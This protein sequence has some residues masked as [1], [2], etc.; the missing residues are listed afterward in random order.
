MIR[1]LPAILA[2][3]LAACSSD[4]AVVHADAEADTAPDVAAEVDTAPDVAPDV[5]PD[6]PP[7]V[8][9][10]ADPGPIGCLHDPACEKVFLSAHRAKCGGEPENTLAGIE[11]CLD[12]GIPML[13][14]DT[15]ATADGHIVLMHDGDTERTTDGEERHPD[16]YAVGDLTLAEFEA[17]VVDDERCADDPEAT[18][19]RCHPPS[20]ADALAALQGHDAVFFIDLKGGDPARIVREAADAGLEDQIV[21]FDSGL[22][23]LAAGRAEAPG[24]EVMARVHDTDELQALLDDP[25]TASLDL[26]WVHVD[27][28][29]LADARDLL[30]DRPVRLYCNA[31]VEVDGFWAIARSTGDDDMK[32]VALSNLDT[33]VDDGARALGCELCTSWHDAL[34]ERDLVP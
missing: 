26:R 21:L 3:L 23:K 22:D 34:G 24:V 32:A 17:L 18:P 5:S 6:V 20:W 1:A 31:F 15:R 19:T 13:E 14:V 28:D 33:L 27:G 25:R 7:D 8:P 10:T 11:A 4:D 30:G 2:L 9:P 16:G 12:A 29:W